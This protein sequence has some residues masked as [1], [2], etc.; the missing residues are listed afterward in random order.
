MKKTILIS[1]FLVLM[2]AFTSCGGKKDAANNVPANNSK[3]GVTTKKSIKNVDNTM[4]SVET[5][6][7]SL[8]EAADI[9]ID[10]L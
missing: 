1:I 4:K 7:D 2:I 5:T 8:E 10:N 6:V 9:N 3:A